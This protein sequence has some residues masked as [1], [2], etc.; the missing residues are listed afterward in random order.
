MTSQ[1]SSTRTRQ[2]LHNAAKFS[3]SHL[4][5]MLGI[6]PRKICLITGCPRTGTSAMFFWLHAHKQ[7][8][9]LYESRILISAHRFVEEVERFQTLHENKRI[10]ISMIR[11]LI[12]TYYARTRY[13]WRKQLLVEKEPLEPTAFPDKCYGQFLRNVRI[14]F[15]EIKLLFMLR[16][17]VA[18]TWSMTQRPWGYSLTNQNLRTYSLEECISNWQ[19]CAELICEYASV[20][21][22]YVCRFEQFIADPV[23]DSRRIMDF[24]SIRSTKL[25]QPQPTSICGFSDAEREFILRET[26]SQREMLSK[27]GMGDNETSKT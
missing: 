20:Q 23:A 13:L 2:F 25:F 5:A 7:V 27:L 1:Q 16:D 19:A 17:P 14:I 12:Y 18:T 3:F 22:V 15:P 4:Q 24:L 9:A 6:Y 21:N 26:R 8:A 11:R 10:V